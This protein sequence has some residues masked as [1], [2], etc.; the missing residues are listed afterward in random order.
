MRGWPSDGDDR[1][2]TRMSVLRV[3]SGGKNFCLFVQ[4]FVMGQLE[5]RELSTQPTS[6]PPSSLKRPIPVALAYDPGPRARPCLELLRTWQWY[7]ACALLTTL[8]MLRLLF[9]SDRITN[10]QNPGECRQV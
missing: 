2:R 7:V 8:G 6:V 5:R 10:V 1:P 4:C 9:Y 3:E